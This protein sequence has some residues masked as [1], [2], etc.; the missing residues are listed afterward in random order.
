M[1]LTLPLTDDEIKA[2]RTTGRRISADACSGQD[3]M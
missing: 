1:I 3:M 2:S